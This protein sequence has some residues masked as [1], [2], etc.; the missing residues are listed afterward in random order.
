MVEGD[1]YDQPWVQ[2]LVS[3]QSCV[4]LLS[5][6]LLICKLGIFPLVIAVLLTHI[7]EIIWVWQIVT[8]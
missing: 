7:K 1:G 8:P 3:S 5:L 4:A 2:I 6:R